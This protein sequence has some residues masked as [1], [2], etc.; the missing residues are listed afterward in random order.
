MDL[1]WCHNP[2]FRFP[3][4]TLT[5]LYRLSPQHLQRWK[6]HNQLPFFDPRHLF[7]LLLCVSSC[8]SLYWALLVPG[9]Y[10]SR[11][12]HLYVFFGTI[13]YVCESFVLWFGFVPNK[14]LVLDKYFFSNTPWFDPSHPPLRSKF[15]F[16]WY[17]QRSRSCEDSEAHI[18]INPLG[19]NNHISKWE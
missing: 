17:S 14:S 1:T 5:S 11:A 8:S 3:N 12:L 2:P 19:V 7:S 15:L 13:L 10:L 4:T 9:D 6:A 16:P 18:T